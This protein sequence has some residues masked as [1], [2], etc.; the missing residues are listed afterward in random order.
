MHIYIYTYL[1][2]HI[3]IKDLGPKAANCMEH[4]EFYT[5]FYTCLSSA[6]KGLESF[7][8][9]LCLGGKIKNV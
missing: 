1:H 5:E 2:T 3:Y 8:V 4:T 6:K 9:F 7:L